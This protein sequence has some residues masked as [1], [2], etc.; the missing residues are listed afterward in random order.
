MKRRLIFRNNQKDSAPYLLGT[1]KRHQSDVNKPSRSVGFSLLGVI[2]AIF[3]TTVGLVAIL[4]LA[5][6]A[7]K[8]AS[9]SKMKL[10][11]SGLAQE[12][13]ELVR[14]MRRAEIEWDAWYSAVPNGDYRVQYD[15]YT[16][17]D[18]MSYADVPLR[19]DTGSRLYQYSSG[20]NSPFYRRINLTTISADEV[21]VIVEIKWQTKGRWHYL[22]VE[23][24]LWNWK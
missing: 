12:G 21:R 6:I 10:I 19:L 8:G 20:S 15:S 7:L 2:V 16:L 22:T 11:A 3:I 17:S 5:N 24:R 14:S 18:L 4:N 1:E 13:I 23:D 9:P